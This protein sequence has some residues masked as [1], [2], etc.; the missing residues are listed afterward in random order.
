[1]LNQY[2]MP[3]FRILSLRYK[4]V[5]QKKVLYFSPQGY[6]PFQIMEIVITF[7]LISQI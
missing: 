5:E 3:F 6:Y 1:M 2:L 4:F 7:L